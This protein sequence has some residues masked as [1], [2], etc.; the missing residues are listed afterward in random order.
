LRSNL[1]YFTGGADKKIILITSSISGEGKTFT[2][3]N[4]ATVMAFA[5]KKVIIV[6]ADMRKPKIF[7]DFKLGNEKGLSSYLSG[8]NPLAECIQ[9]T[10][11]EN[12]HLLSSGPV[13]PNPSELLMGPRT[14]DLIASAGT[15]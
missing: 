13:P 14:A 5:G 7:G 4:L 3:I 1:N 11:I 6:G 9:P 2:T 8:I 15:V 10:Q 12:L